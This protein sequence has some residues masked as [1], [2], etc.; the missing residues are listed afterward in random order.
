MEVAE[1]QVEPKAELVELVIVPW[2]N[3]NIKKLRITVHQDVGHDI[4]KIL[5]TDDEMLVGG[6]GKEPDAQDGNE[7]APDS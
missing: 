1:V 3:E 6:K 5:D 2:T 4:I 7:N